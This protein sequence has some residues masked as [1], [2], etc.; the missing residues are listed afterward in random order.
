MK[1][2]VAC[3][4]EVR[5]AYRTLVRKPKEKRPFGDFGVDWRIIQK[6]I[7]TNKTTR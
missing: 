3:M 2:N 4:E 7:L 5:K 6:L 1:G